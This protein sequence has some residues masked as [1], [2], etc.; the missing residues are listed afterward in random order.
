MVTVERLCGLSILTTIE[1]NN[2]RAD[3][4]RDCFLS[5]I[6]EHQFPLQVRG[7]EGAENRMIA[8][9]MIAIRG[10]GMRCFIGGEST[11]G[12]RAC[13]VVSAL[14]PPVTVDL[15]KHVCTCQVCQSFC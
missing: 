12:T 14:T 13:T 7:D 8:K 11:R 3:A 15:I 9:H 4:A 2:N 1:Q 6:E 10:E 5:A